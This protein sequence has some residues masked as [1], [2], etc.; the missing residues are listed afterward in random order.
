MVECLPGSIRPVSHVEAEFISSEMVKTVSQLYGF[1]SEAGLC[2]DTFFDWRSV[3]VHFRL[4]D[5]DE[6]AS[7]AWAWA[8]K[9]VLK[10][11]LFM[12]QVY[13]L[14]NH[15]DVVQGKKVMQL[16]F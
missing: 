4:L 16:H 13:F 2:S 9:L 6:F 14:W 5:L 12:D 1:C 11:A 15:S 7:S 10:K 3:E 8:L